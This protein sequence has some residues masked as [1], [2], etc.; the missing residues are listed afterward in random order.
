[1]VAD[2]MEVAVVAAVAVAAAVVVAAALAAIQGAMQASPLGPGSL[3]A[4]LTALQGHSQMFL[5]MDFPRH[6]TT[7]SATYRPPK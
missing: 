2:A 6:S 5:R 3:P 4:A 1:M 7:T